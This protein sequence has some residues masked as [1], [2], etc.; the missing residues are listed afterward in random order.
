MHVTGVLASRTS[1]PNV[2]GFGEGG[3]YSA[4]SSDDIITSIVKFLDEVKPEFDPVVTGSPTIPVD[5]LNPTTVLPYAYY[6]SFIPKPQESTQLW[7]GQLK[8]I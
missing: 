1:L 3:F 6:S 5:S 2:G 7:A 8:Q 4:Q